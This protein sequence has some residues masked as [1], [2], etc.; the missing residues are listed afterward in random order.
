[1]R[2][3]RWVLAPIVIAAFGVGWMQ[4]AVL[5]YERTTGR[6]SYGLAGYYYSSPEWGFRYHPG[7]ELIHRWTTIVPSYSTL[8]VLSICLFAAVIAERKA[9]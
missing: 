8:A 7:G 3:V 4:L 6:E 5:H 2:L 1:M 9:G